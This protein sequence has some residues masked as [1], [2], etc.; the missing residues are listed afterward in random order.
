MAGMFCCL[1]GVF[2]FLDVQNVGRERGLGNEAFKLIV[3]P[4]RA[5][6]NSKFRT[7]AA[8]KGSIN[9]PPYLHFSLITFCCLVV[10]QYVA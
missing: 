6:I 8:R 5:L 3:D 1:H 9:W 7:N 4:S 10:Q 2:A